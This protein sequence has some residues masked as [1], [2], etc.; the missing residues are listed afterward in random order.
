MCLKRNIP[1]FSKNVIVLWDHGWLLCSNSPTWS[2]H[3]YPVQG[4]LHLQLNSWSPVF[5]SIFDW[6]V[7]PFLQSRFWHILFFSRWISFNLSFKVLWHWSF[8]I[9]TSANLSQSS[10]SLPSPLHSSPPQM[11]SFFS[12]ARNFF[13]MPHLS[14]QADQSPH[15]SHVQS[16]AIYWKT[17]L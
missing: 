15:S 5:G 7:P 6:Q 1:I 3:V 9:F 8:S 14:G 10:S 13:E 16:T 12:L 17:S 11:C 4:C 2:A